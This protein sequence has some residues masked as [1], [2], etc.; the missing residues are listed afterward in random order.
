MLVDVVANACIVAHE[1]IDLCMQ[2]LDGLLTVHA[3]GA[4]RAG[5]ARNVDGQLV[6]LESDGLTGEILLKFGAEGTTLRG[7]GIDLLCTK[8]AISSVEFVA[9]SE[10]LKQL[11]E[12]RV[13]ERIETQ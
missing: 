1:L 2:T 11:E 4:M 7:E 13:G 8:E 12:V 6:H 5:E 10:Q 3:D 9:S